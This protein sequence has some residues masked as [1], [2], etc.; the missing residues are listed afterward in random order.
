[1]TPDVVFTAPVNLGALEFRDVVAERDLE[2][3][4]LAELEV[5]LRELGTGF[6]FVKRQYTFVL[7]GDTFAIDLLC[8]DRGVPAAAAP[9][10]RARASA[11]ERASR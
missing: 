8:Y 1:M 7:D 11:R 4:I 9:R 5:F 10:R 6:A 3:A 2:A